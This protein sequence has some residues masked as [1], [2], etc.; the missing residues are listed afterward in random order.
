MKGREYTF[1]T[2]TISGAY[3]QVKNNDLIF[4]LTLKP[5]DGK[6]FK[7]ERVYDI[8]KIRYYTDLSLLNSSEGI[9]KVAFACFVADEDGYCKLSVSQKKALCTLMRKFPGEFDGEIEIGEV[10]IRIRGTDAELITP[11]R[12]NTLTKP[13]LEFTQRYRSTLFAY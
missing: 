2:S 5:K 12:V 8:N 10:L 3:G 1:I 7:L 4:T 11:W 9:T 6:E 13:L